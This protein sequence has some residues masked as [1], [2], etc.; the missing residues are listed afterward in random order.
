MKRFEVLD[1]YSIDGLICV[2]HGDAEEWQKDALDYASYLLSS[3]GVSE[4]F[5]VNR[6]KEIKGEYEIHLKNEF[7]ERAHESYNIFNLIYISAFWLREIFYGWYLKKDGY[8]KKHRQRLY[9]LGAGI[10]LYTAFI[11]NAMLSPNTIEQNKIAEI[12]AIAFRDSLNLATTDWSGIYEFSDISKDST[13]IIAWELILEKS[14]PNH[15]GI[16]KLA[17]KNE[18]LTIKCVGLIKDQD[19]EFY[20][21]TTYYLFD[22]T[23]ISY[24]DNLFSFS[25]DES[26]LMTYWAKMKPFF[27]HKDNQIN[28]FKKKDSREKEL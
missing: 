24:Y 25:R 15:L 14:D 18:A 20:P 6:F 19:I 1:D 2:V 5:A 27:D 7:A 9:A 23:E 21:D 22:N 3:K 28:L 26:R 16:L 11:I 4:E 12:S 10:I 8:I 17:K 13:E